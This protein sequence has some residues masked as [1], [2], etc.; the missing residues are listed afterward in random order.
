MLYDRRTVI[1]R[2][3]TIKGPTISIAVVVW[4]KHAIFHNV[5]IKNWRVDASSDNYPFNK[6]MGFIIASGCYDT[7]HPGRYL[8]DN[9]LYYA[10]QPIGKSRVVEGPLTFTRPQSYGLA[11]LLI[12]MLCRITSHRRWQGR[13]RKGHLIMARH[14]QRERSLRKPRSTSSGSGHFGGQSN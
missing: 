7:A 4:S 10:L 12:N 14:I 2:S 11:S 13:R 3:A 9:S 6:P 8:F 5:V 1:C